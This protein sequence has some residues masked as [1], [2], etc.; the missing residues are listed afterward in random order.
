MPEDKRVLIHEEIAS[1]AG[2]K[3]LGNHRCQ[4]DGPTAL[5][6]ILKS[7]NGSIQNVAETKE[8]QKCLSRKHHE[9]G[10]LTAREMQRSV[11]TYRRKTD[12]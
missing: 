6:D 7:R 12:E 3:K 1:Q 10:H 4:N 9:P 11:S 8:I 2:A 5:P